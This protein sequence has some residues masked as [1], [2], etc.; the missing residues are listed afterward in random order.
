MAWKVYN[1]NI[2]CNKFNGYTLLPRQKASYKPPISHVNLT[3]VLKT[4]PLSREKERQNK[5]AHNDSN[6]DNRGP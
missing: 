6:E 3:I 2:N 5:Q 4:Y 1:N